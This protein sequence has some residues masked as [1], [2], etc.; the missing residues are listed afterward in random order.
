M[1]RGLMRNVL[2]I[3][4]G[5]MLLAPSSFFAQEQSRTYPEERERA[6]VQE[7]NRAT[8]ATF[9]LR[10]KAKVSGE[11]I[12]RDGDSLILRDDAGRDVRV[13]LTSAT[14]ITEKKSNPFRGARKFTP[15]QLV[16]GLRLEAEGLG[17]T[18]GAL[19]ARDIKFTM[20]QLLVAQSVEDRVVPVEGRLG[21]TESRLTRSEE[22]AK[23]L[24]G[25]VDELMA[26]SNAARGGAKAAQETADQAMAGVNS[27]NQKIEAVDQAANARITAVDEYEVK[28]TLSLQFKVGSAELTPEAKAM[29]EQLASAAVAQKG[30][31][32]EVA[33]Y[34]SADGPEDYNRV[35]SRRRAEAVVQYLADNTVP[36]RRIVIPVG[37]GENLPIA[38][39]KTRA[40][41][42]ENRRVEVK[43][44]VSKG[45][46]GGTETL[47]SSGKIR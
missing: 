1:L 21:E 17:D 22:S 2:G 19:A 45:L 28:N 41:R 32:I 25:Q 30:Y 44:L 35:L 9:E 12:R 5:L 39:N 47:A 16:R 40:G 10:Q 13:K 27:A 38:D 14:E 31:V 37:F 43:L 18:D 15:D 7:Q 6:S 3:A 26:V 23:H 42:Q 24:S 46:A 34:A 36:A 33:G 29:L 8:T 11:L 4:A 20:T